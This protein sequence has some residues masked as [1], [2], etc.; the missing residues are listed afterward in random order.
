MFSIRYNRKRALA[1][2]EI[3]LASS[4]NKM[5]ILQKSNHSTG[6]GLQKMPFMIEKVF[7]KMI[8]RDFKMP[9]AGRKSADD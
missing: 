1:K 9:F 7:S 8:L 4:S 6:R 3:K 2:A 5:H